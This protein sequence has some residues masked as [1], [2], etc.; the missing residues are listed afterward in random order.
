MS[1]PLESD[2]WQEYNQMMRN[3]MDNVQRILEKAGTNMGA[4]VTDNTNNMNVNNDGSYRGWFKAKQPDIQINEDRVVVNIAIDK[5]V[6]QEN[7]QV[8]LE[9]N[10]LII[11]GALQS[12]IALPVAVKKYGGKAVCRQGILEITLG[13]DKYAAKQYIPIENE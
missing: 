13:R 12:K 4:A 8:Y 9:G 1:G 5:V 11:N 2:F 10:N 7:T 3:T 6:N